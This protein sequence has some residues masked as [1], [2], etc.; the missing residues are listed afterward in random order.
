MYDKLNAR[1]AVIFIHPTYPYPRAAPMNVSGTLRFDFVTP[2]MNLFQAPTLEFIFDTTRTFADVITSGTVATNANLKWIIPHCGAAMPAVLDRFIRIAN[3]LG[4]KAGSDRVSLPY[5]TTPAIALM[6]RH[7]WFD[8]AGFSMQTQIWTMARL[9]GADR[10]TY[11][12]DVPFTALPAA[13]GFAGEMNTI[14]PQLFNCLPIIHHP[15]YEGSVETWS[16]HLVAHWIPRSLRRLS[17]G[18]PFPRML[19]EA[20]LPG[21]S[22]GTAPR[23]ALYI[24]YVVA[25][26]TLLPSPRDAATS[27]RGGEGDATTSWLGREGDAATS[28]RGREEL[29]SALTGPTMVVLKEFSG[30]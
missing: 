21:S 6:K 7:F 3:I 29:L 9:F 13:I 26:M 11:S 23:V 22:E 17:T 5:N 25:G 24:S 20:E 14:L 2:L 12:S 27:W 28:W 19:S 4:L 15:V 10:F 1:E 16:Y 8:A 18:I 30:S